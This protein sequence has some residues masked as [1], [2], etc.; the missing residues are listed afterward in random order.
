MSR[1]DF[2]SSR[3]IASQRWFTAVELD[4]LLQHYQSLGFSLTQ[5]RETE[6][7]RSGQFFFFPKRNYKSDG[8]DWVR[9]K[10][11]ETVREDMVRISMNGVHV[12]TGR[13][14]YS[15]ATPGLCRRT[16][17]HVTNGNSI[18][19]VH[20]RLCP[21]EEMPKRAAISSAAKVREAQVE[22]D[23]TSE[24]ILDER[25]VEEL[26]VCAESMGMSFANEPMITGLLDQSFHG[27]CPS[28][29]TSVE[30][31]VSHQSPQNSIIDFEP[32][33]HYP[34]EVGGENQPA[35]AVIVCL[36]S[37]VSDAEKIFVIFGDNEVK[38]P[39]IYL[40]P[41]AL[42]C[43]VPKLQSRHP[44]RSLHFRIVSSSGA[45]ITLPSDYPFAFDIPSPIQLVEYRPTGTF[46]EDAANSRVDALVFSDFLNSPYA[47]PSLGKD[48]STG[49]NTDDSL[50]HRLPSLITKQELP[51]AM[52]R[53]DNNI[54]ISAPSLQLPPLPDAGGL[55]PT[56]EHNPQLG[57][58]FVEKL[59]SVAAV[60]GGN[61]GKRDRD[62][63]LSISK[64]DGVLVSPPKASD[65]AHAPW[66]DGWLD[67][68]ALNKLSNS[69]LQELVDSFIGTYMGQ[70]VHLASV[71]S[72]LRQELNLL[73]QRYAAKRIILN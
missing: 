22:T 27:D 21:L 1:L 54:G 37:P 63:Q 2:E 35:T 33:R 4:F 57:M 3:A 72:E 56:T 31:I 9:K 73:D 58:R 41:Y 68:K 5:V 20:Y 17:E 60:L 19:M 26:M 28:S 12:V 51:S 15:L 40:S 8:Y 59:G 49:Y 69:E 52:R 32:R 50:M 48:L 42:K 46:S 23:Y 55:R 47:Q 24:D 70:L 7:P 45:N 10:G 34:C 53:N 29:D 66:S 18:C 38:I 14:T 71:D 43:F 25:L 36:A 11:R 39:A 67:D 64:S 44:N 61:G 16:Y 65:L 62:D 6:F 30:A 13:Y